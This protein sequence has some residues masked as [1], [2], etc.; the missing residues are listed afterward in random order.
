MM[1]ILREWEAQNA[2]PTHAIPIYYM[3]AIGKAAFC[4]NSP[5]D[6]EI[7]TREKLVLT[8]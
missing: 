3:A 1:P 2:P 7:A 4:I 6:G 5:P 8:R